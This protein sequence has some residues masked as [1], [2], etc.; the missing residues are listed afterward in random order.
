MTK[1]ET[2]I[3]RRTFLRSALIVSGG[4]LMNACQI[5]SK[6]PNLPLS[7]S[8][9]VLSTET[10]TPKPTSIQTKTS[11]PSPTIEVK[12]ALAEPKLGMIGEAFVRADELPAEMKK[13]IPL[14]ESNKVRFKDGGN[15]FLPYGVVRE[16]VSDSYFFVRDYLHLRYLGEAKVTHI[17]YDERV[18]EWMKGIRFYI[19]DV[20]LTK[21]NLITGQEEADVGK[22][23]F[24]GIFF[25]LQ[26]FNGPSVYEVRNNNFRDV[27]QRIFMFNQVA[28]RVRKLKPGTSVVLGIPLRSSQDIQ[29]PDSDRDIQIVGQLSRGNIVSADYP[30]GGNRNRGVSVYDIIYLDSSYLELP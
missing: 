5:E 17:P 28:E 14:A 26:T 2:K 9:R 10:P 19:F 11:S 7:I 3:D 21:Q 15:G 30:L 23:Q 22:R 12:E 8:P 25:V 27:A 24:L 6:K 29:S 16:E 20:P 13:E 4:A 1:V 18:D